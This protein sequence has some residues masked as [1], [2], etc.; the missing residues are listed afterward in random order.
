[1]NRQGANVKIV[2]LQAAQGD[3]LIL[4]VPTIPDKAL[5]QL[6]TGDNVH[7]IAHSETGHHHVVSASTAKFFQVPTDM[8]T[9]YLEIAEDTTVKHLRDYDTHE[10]FSLLKWKY[11]IRRQRE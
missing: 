8:L 7:I 10:S 5:E 1:M 2:K 9:S 4:R 3:L 11:E 6:A